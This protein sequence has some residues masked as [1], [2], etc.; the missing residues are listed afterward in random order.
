ML[1]VTLKLLRFVRRDGPTYRF[2]VQAALGIFSFEP[3]YDVSGTASDI[4][5]SLPN[6]RY[7]CFVHGTASVLW[8]R[9]ASA[10]TD[11]GDYFVAR[12]G[13]YFCFGDCGNSVWSRV[14]TTARYT[15]TVAV[16][17]ARESGRRS[18]PGKRFLELT[19]LRSYRK[20]TDRSSIGA[21]RSQ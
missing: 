9:R 2:L 15:G 1:P 13:Q 14:T 11:D 17:R 5:E 16:A 20:E 12:G 6:G 10:P 19:D 21:I 4:R 7:L 3:H 8:A 18:I